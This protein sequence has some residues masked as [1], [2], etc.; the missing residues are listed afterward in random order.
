MKLSVIIIA[1]NEAKI[2]KDCLGSVKSLA[3]E[4]IL[5]DNQSTD[6]T[7]AVAKS[8]GAKVFAGVGDYSQLRN[9]GLKAASGDWIFYLDADE[10]VTSQLA[11]EIL[12]VIDNPLADSYKLPR[13]YI[14]LNR[15]IRHAGY[16]PDPTHRLFK[17]PALKK[18]TGKLHESPHVT[19]PI[20][21]LKHPLLHSSPRS[22]TAA[23]EKSRSW[24]EIEAK[25]LF[26]AHAPKVTGLKIL[27]AFCAHLFRQLVLRRGLFDGVPGLILAY[28]QAIHQASILINLWQ[29]QTQPKTSA[30]SQNLPK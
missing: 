7:A 19:G 5:V 11:Q 14:F 17:K 9:M 21:Q 23:L 28:I 12:S 6:K 26:E 24:A 18:W 13:Q 8:T 27:K 20:G 22:I 2:I 3:D 15:W 4:I 30:T 10:R 16:W 1:K 29:L 25:L